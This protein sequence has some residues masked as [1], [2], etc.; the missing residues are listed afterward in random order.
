MVRRIVRVAAPLTLLLPALGASFGGCAGRDVTVGT[1]RDDTPS[2][3]TP[4]AATPPD[5]AAGELTSYCASDRC[6][7]GRVTCPDSLYLCDVDLL[8]DVANCG[9]C[10]NQCPNESI[11]A[12]GRCALS[13]R[14]EEGDCDGIPDNGCEAS[15]YSAD[16][17]GFCGNK[18][19]DGVPCV[20]RGIL[21]LHCGCKPGELNCGGFIL[22]CID[23][24]NDDTNCGACG[25]ACPPDG[26]G[27]HELKPNTYLGC[28]NGEC[29]A[30]KCKAN[31]GDCDHNPENGCEAP[32]LDDEN[33]GACGNR[34][35]DGAECGLMVTFS[36]L[37]PT[38]MCPKS[39]TFCGGRLD[40]GGES[41]KLG[42]C[43]NLESDP[44]NCGGCGTSCPNSPA[45]AEP[46]CVYGKCKY[47][48]EPGW[49]DCN[50]TTIDGCETRTASDPNNCGACGVVCDAI[51]GQACVDGRCM[52]EPCEQ[53]QDA[54][55]TPR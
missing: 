37:V 49:G 32:L 52:V 54:G 40:M 22:P 51:A 19:P 28:G 8:T 47:D 6:P 9:E 31:F 15:M 36:G 20:D 50:A 42:D 26:S 3:E 29:A 35:T 14:L 48:C 30:L 5:A 41:F 18:C 34:C 24:M 38:C 4:D 1:A 27:I 11:C 33:C 21:D 23:P 13:C 55:G 39:P 45:N 10:G 43:K 17:C 46:S 2:F 53:L 7:T 44:D 16:N 25:N 12:D